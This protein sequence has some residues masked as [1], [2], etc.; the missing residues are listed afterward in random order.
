MGNAKYKRRERIMKAEK[1]SKH[2]K[3]MEKKESKKKKHGI[4]FGKKAAR[5]KHDHKEKY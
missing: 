3:A 2:E 1:E 5:K 4:V